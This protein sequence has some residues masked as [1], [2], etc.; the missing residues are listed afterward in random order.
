MARGN[1]VSKG[2]PAVLHC[3]Q[4]FFLFWLRGSGVQRA[5]TGCLLAAAGSQA[6]LSQG[7]DTGVWSNWSAW[8]LPVGCTPVL[9]RNTTRGH[10]DWKPLRWDMQRGPG[11]SSQNQNVLNFSFLFGGRVICSN[12]FK[13]W[14]PV[15]VSDTEPRYLKRDV[16]QH[17]HFRWFWFP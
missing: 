6:A 13:C 9:A 3:T 4:V 5:G 16:L 14:M 1:H 11:F 2:S 7:T 17:L 12:S 8:T 15:P 10:P